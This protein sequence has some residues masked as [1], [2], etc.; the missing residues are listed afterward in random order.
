MTNRATATEVK[1]ILE[2]TLSDAVVTAFID[3][4][5]RVVSDHL[6]ANTNISTAQKT[7]IE[8]WLAAHMIAST[9]EQQAQAEAAGDAKITYQGETGKGLESTHYGQMVMMLDTTGTLANAIGGKTVSILAITTKPR[10]EWTPN[11]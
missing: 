7:D 5:N 10:N 11:T 4:A 1:I 9:R 6:G 8:K 3:A 2:T